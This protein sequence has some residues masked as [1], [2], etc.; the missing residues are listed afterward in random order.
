[1]RNA[2]ALAVLSFLAACSGDPAMYGITG[3]GTQPA[4]LTPTAGGP[5]PIPDPGIPSPSTFYGPTTR[6]T[7]GDSGFWGYN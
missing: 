2:L 1:M 5:D 7:T 6:P 3:P 4:A